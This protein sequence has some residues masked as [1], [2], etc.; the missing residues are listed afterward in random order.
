MQLL[1]KSTGAIIYA[2]VLAPVIWMAS[3][4]AKRRLA[5]ILG[6][7]VLLYPSLRGADLF[8]VDTV[9]SLASMIN[10]DREGSMAYRFTDEDILLKKARQRP[11][12]GWGFYDRNQGFNKWGKVETVTDGEW[13]IR[14]GVTGFVGF[15]IQFGLLLWP[16]FAAGRKMRKVY[17]KVNRRLIA[18]LSLILA[19]CAVDLL[20]NS[21]A[22]NY[23]YLLAGALLSGA[24]ARAQAVRQEYLAPTT[25]PV[26]A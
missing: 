9:K 12:F 25:A 14:L 11:V 24:A 5:V 7:L 4:R 22:S 13:I 23:P 17:D 1:C 19:M 2:A 21:L 10:A 15:G 8:P 6:V 26:A 20:P 18:G 16:L 3:Y